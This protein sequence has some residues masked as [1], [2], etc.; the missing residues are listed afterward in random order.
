MVSP[1]VAPRAL[2]HADLQ[3]DSNPVGGIR[4]GAPT[5]ETHMVARVTLVSRA[6]DAQAA[7]RRTGGM[8]V[9]PSEC[10]SLMVAGDNGHMDRANDTRPTMARISRPLHYPWAILTLPVG[11]SADDGCELH[12]GISPGTKDAWHA[13][14]RD[15]RA[16][17]RY[18]WVRWVTMAFWDEEAGGPLELP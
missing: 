1:W 15:L 6:P 3:A 7:V 10:M 4:I 8:S 9:W 13:Y 2:E 5:H 12:A 17:G 16:T 11:E 14:A 18:E